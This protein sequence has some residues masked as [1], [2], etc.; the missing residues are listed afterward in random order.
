MKSIAIVS[1]KGGSGKTTVA[2][3]LAV[4]AQEQGLQSII[5]DLDPQASAAMWGAQRGGKKRP[6]AV[7]STQ[8][9]ML[10][11]VLSTAKEQGFDLAFID[12]APHADSFALAA[13]EEADVVFVPCRPSIMDVR[14][15]GNTYRICRLAEKTAHII[16][17]QVD[18]SGTLAE[19]AKTT[20]YKAGGKVCSV[21]IF[22]VTLGRRVAFH[23]G[24]IN[25]ETALEY[26]PNGTAAQE[27]REL[28]K[29]ARRLDALRAGDEEER[30]VANG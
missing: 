5:I 28:L 11:S 20:L 12:T 25:G 3:H 29:H 23:H 8:P 1:Q 4:A 27:V 30:Q 9:A 7:I 10:K 18:P 2:L 14:A 19:E 15:M 6:P 17:T 26:E 21:E 24:L 22:P 13:A 16:L